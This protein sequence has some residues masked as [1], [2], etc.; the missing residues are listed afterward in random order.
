MFKRS[1]GRSLPAPG[2]GLLCRFHH[3]YERERELGLLARFSAPAT[4]EPQGTG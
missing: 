2:L 4:A 3:R 1:R